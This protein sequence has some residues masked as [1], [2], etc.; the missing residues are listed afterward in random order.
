MQSSKF[1]PQSRTRASQ[2]LSGKRLHQI[3][4]LKYFLTEDMKENHKVLKW[5]SDLRKCRR[6]LEKQTNKKPTNVLHTAPQKHNR[7]QTT[8]YRQGDMTTIRFSR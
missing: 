2:T 7:K 3:A 5:D 6:T 4:V 1:C 8:S